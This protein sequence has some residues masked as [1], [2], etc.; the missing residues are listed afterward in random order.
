[1]NTA[2]ERG[3]ENRGESLEGMLRALIPFSD[4]TSIQRECVVGASAGHGGE[5]VCGAS[6]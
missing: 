3:D 2:V 6:R 4:V 1:M 5:G